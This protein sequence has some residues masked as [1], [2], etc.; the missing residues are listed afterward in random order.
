MIVGRRPRLATRGAT[1]AAVVAVVLLA[2]AGAHGN[3]DSPEEAE[4]SFWEQ[5]E[6]AYRATRRGP[7][8]AIRA[9]YLEPREAL[10]LYVVGDSLTTDADTP[11]DRGAAVV[12][13]FAEAGFA[14]SPVEAK[15]WDYPTLGSVPVFEIQAVG[16]TVGDDEDLRVGRFLLSF[17]IQGEGLGR[18]L[19]YDPDLLETRFQGFPV[20]PAD[21]RYRLEARLTAAAGD[22]LVLGTSRGLEKSYVRAARL[23]FEVA[24][25]ACTLTGFRA[26]GDDGTALFVPFTDA[27]SGEGSYGVGRYLRVVPR[28][29]GTAEIDFHRATN[30]WCAYSPFYNCVLPPLENQLE[31]EIR[32]GERAPAGEH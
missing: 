30:P 19:A 23:D 7:F 26:P 5:R 27:T 10:R 25:T 1:A 31:V 17:G 28:E 3:D 12:I 29:D 6:E 22:T 13:R 11:G 21:G 24:G 32:A 18:V 20:F 9:D 16:K 14:V 4:G 15:G 2:A 8:T